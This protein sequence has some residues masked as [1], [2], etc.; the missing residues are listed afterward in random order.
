MRK[1][2]ENEGNNSSKS[3]AMENEWGDSYGITMGE[4]ISL[5]VLVVC[6]NALNW[7]VHLQDS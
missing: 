5:G 2:I 6:T 4:N 1:K 3:Q 7:P